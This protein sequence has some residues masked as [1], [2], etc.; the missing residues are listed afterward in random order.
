MTP[1]ITVIIPCYN[2][3]KY[4][5]RCL[6]CI[7]KQTYES[8]EVLLIDD[9]ST[10]RSVEIAAE[11]KGVKVISNDCNRGLAYTRNRG[12]E[13]A[14]GKYVHYFDVDDR[15]NSTYYEGLAAAAE[16]T[17]ADIIISG[18]IFQRGSY[19]TQTFDEIRTYSGKE[20]YAIS[21]PGRWSYVWRYLFR[22]EMLREHRLTFPEGR[23][24]EDIPYTV[25]AFYYARTVATAPGT[26]YLYIDNEGSILTTRD[27]AHKLRRRR[28]R[29]RS[30]EEVRRFAEEK[31]ERIPGVNGGFVRF[32]LE[33]LRR[34]LFAS[35]QTVLTEDLKQ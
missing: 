11:Y 6:D 35:R 19:H 18:V 9:G 5:H 27:E 15:I 14:R 23:L 4:V 13:V 20:K 10:D 30:R 21:W 1:L 33:Y 12:V 2:G 7:Q 17:D 22:T 29:H 32:G 3:E 28:D 8:L 26:E 34:R 24:M 31:G 16:A 25:P